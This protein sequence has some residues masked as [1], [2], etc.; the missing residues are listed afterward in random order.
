MNEF[1]RFL[2]KL[3]L[4]GSLLL[5][6]AWFLFFVILPDDYSETLAIVYQKQ[7][8]LSKSASPKIIL[9][10]G[11]NV[12][13]GVDSALLE[14]RLGR[15][16]VNMAI[17]ARIPLLMQMNQIESFLA[18]NDLIILPLE[19]LY[20]VY[21]DGSTVVIAHLL[22][23][24]PQGILFLDP[25]NQKALPEIVKNIFQ[26]RYDRLK[27]AAAVRFPSW[28]E[29]LDTGNHLA[30][31]LLS[32]FTPRG[33]FEA[34]LD[35]AGLPVAPQPLL[36]MDQFNPRTLQIINEMALRAQQKGSMTVLTFPSARQSNCLATQ[37]ALQQLYQRLQSNLQVPLVGTPECYC[38][39]DEMFFD[40]EYHLLR[41]GRRIRTEQM[42][43]D[44][45]AFIK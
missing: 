15:P 7:A 28:G 29:L 26:M 33:D 25:V 38:F 6:L 43:V 39:P 3:A 22:D 9:L 10:G 40:T 18:S 36:Q 42:A 5:L 24:Y 45:K 16:V 13:L 27:K 20:Y 32:Q 14:Q 11:S 23:I 12:L 30:Q 37:P 8:Y 4:F 19:Y 34:H 35:R 2:G 21:P 44:L 41:E 1:L 31:S 17:H